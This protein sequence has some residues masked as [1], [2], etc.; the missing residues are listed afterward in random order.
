MF[1]GFSA[2][3]KA[4]LQS[5]REECER[6]KQYYIGVEHLFLGL[7]ETAGNPL[8]E[9][10][11]E[12][13]VD[14]E[15]VARIRQEM[16]VEVDEPL[17]GNSVIQTPRLQRVLQIAGRLCVQKKRT[18]V[19]PYHLMLAILAEPKSLPM[20]LCAQMGVDL[21]GLQ[22]AVEELAETDARIEIDTTPTTVRTPT[23]DR[24]GRDLT[25]L[26]RAR[27]LDPLIGRESEIEKLAL[28]LRKKTQNNAL[29][30]GE[31]G[32]GKTHLVEGLAEEI[33]FPKLEATKTLKGKR[34]IEIDLNSLVAGTT[35]R[36][37]FE[38]RLEAILKEA[39]DPDIILFIDEFHMILSAGAAS[40]SQGAAQVLKPYLARGEI[41]CIGATTNDE[42]SK[43]I[44]SDK[45]FTRR[46]ETVTLREPTGEETVEILNG[47]ASVYE[48]H[49]YVYIEEDALQACVEFG[50]RYIRNR[51]FPEK[52]IE[53][54]DLACAQESL[55]KTEQTLIQR[56]DIARIIFQKT[57]VRPLADQNV[58]EFLA[59]LADRLAQRVIG[60]PEVIGAVV[61]VIRNAQLGLTRPDRPQGVLLLCGPSGVGKTELARA[62]SDELFPGRNSLIQ[63]NMSEYTEPMAVTAL[64]GAP[65]AYVGFEQ[66]GSLTEAVRRNPFSVVLL[67]EIEKAHSDIWKLLLQVFDEG[68]IMDRNRRMADFTNT[69]IFMTSNLGAEELTSK[70]RPG[71]VSAGAGSGDLQYG[72]LEA[73]ARSAVEKTFSREFRNRIDEI[74]AFRPLT[75]SVLRKIIDKEVSEICQR[76]GLRQSG[77]VLRLDE[78]AY[79][80]IIGAGYSIQYGARELR[81]VIDRMIL[82]PLGAYLSGGK[83]PAG[84]VVVAAV[85]SGRT[86]F[87]LE[88]VRV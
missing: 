74:L 3:A 71:F 7:C 61:N 35:Y 37:D 19:S 44:E 77:V 41:R 13:C 18:Q 63:F 66:G 60:Q 87:S 28:I 70:A 5:A 22:Y 79:H 57:G 45:A 38:A 58:K 48:K 50:A 65:P 43:F 20:R 34:I 73:A 47:L 85:R 76:S 75:T 54:L 26:A 21:I 31:A 80:E 56:K 88:Q 84:S 36:G 33:V 6:S 83:V 42:Y 62:V 9:A 12:L 68:R 27:R 4:A 23:L 10:L 17:W 67:D 39:K 49:Y 24:F 29:I 1:S 11:R 15:V 69:L 8:R 32:A 55:G 30:I 78:S 25:W 72:R 52:A 51:C 82:A 81:R 16:G 86:E 46:F 40:G 2:Q 64:I 59:S 53:L 14:P